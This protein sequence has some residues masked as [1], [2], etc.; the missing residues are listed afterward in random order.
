M[1]K[2]TS[3]PLTKIS[4]KKLDIF[5]FKNHKVRVLHHPSNGEPWFVAY[6]IKKILGISDTSRFVEKLDSDERIKISKSD[7]AHVLNT[8]ANKKSEFALTSNVSTN[9]MIRHIWLISE[10]GL[11]QCLMR[12]NKPIAADFQRWIRKQVLPSIRKT[13]IYL[14][15]NIKQLPKNS[16]KSNL[17]PIEQAERTYKAF[18]S[19]VADFC[20]DADCA[21]WYAIQCT[22]QHL[23]E[24][25]L[26]YFV[27]RMKKEHYMCVTNTR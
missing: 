19:L 17:L 16:K 8:G 10:S 11:Y 5:N 2:Q 9:N 24:V 18:L 14:S 13:G 22:Q 7:F 21:K 26:S 23:P 12:S 15:P 20:S 25:D 1:A 6:D 27:E 4:D 3:L